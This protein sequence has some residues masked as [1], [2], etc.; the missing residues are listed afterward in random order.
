[1]KPIRKLAPLVV[2]LSVM[3]V[4]C[5]NETL[6]PASTFSVE[7]KALTADGQA[8]SGAEI[9]LIRYFHRTKLFVPSVDQMFDC[10]AA[11][12]DIDD[13]DLELGLVRKTTSDMDGRFE[14]EV[15]GEDIIAKTGITD[16]TG[17]KEGSNLVVIVVD[18]D[19]P[20]KDAGVFS[21]ATTFSQGDK[22][23]GAGNMKM[24]DSDAKA[25]VSTSATTGRV[26]LSWKKI[27]RPANSTVSQ[28]YRVEIRGQGRRL[29]LRCDEN[30]TGNSA[31]ETRAL[32]GCVSAGDRLETTVSAFTVWTYYADNGMFTAYVRG[33]GVDFRYREKLTVTAPL[34]DPTMGRDPVLAQ[35]I[36]AVAGV[37]EQELTN[38]KATD[39][40]ITTRESIRNQATQIYVKLA[41]GDVTDA[42]LLNSL[43]SDGYKACVTIEFHGSTFPTLAD[44]RA[45]AMDWVQKGKFCGGGGADN[46]TSALVSFDTTMSDGERAGWMRFVA[47][48]D[49]GL[50]ASTPHFQAIGEVAVFKKK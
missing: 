37:D 9:R 6:D 20:D 35:G 8:I 11:D 29:I 13:F 10:T 47:V 30:V 38:S 33:D 34:P 7:G 12:C 15:L 43:V 19:D 50:S 41:P 39:G 14:I 18:P 42:G 4:A 44:A 23:W 45:A 2:G 40:D 28:R 1:M 46:E 3:S 32:G 26:G 36:W 24:W 22:L 25:D 21:Y 27:V 31:D 16:T 17:K 49:G 5:T 48:P